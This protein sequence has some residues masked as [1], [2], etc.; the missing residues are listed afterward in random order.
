M[1]YNDDSHKFKN[2]KNDQVL[3][4]NIYTVLLIISSNFNDKSIHKLKS[5]RK[6]FSSQSILSV[7]NQANKRYV[8]FQLSQFI[9]K[10]N[11]KHSKNFQRSDFSNDYEVTTLNHQIKN[12]EK[13]IFILNYFSHRLK[14]KKEKKT[15]SLKKHI[16]KWTKKIE[17]LRQEL[18]YY[19]NTRKILMKF[20]ENINES[21]RM[22]KNILCETFKNVAISEQRLLN[23]WSINDCNYVDNVF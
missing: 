5:W 13:T 22:I 7:K 11:I 12:H 9:S 14:L 18:I 6:K 10:R 2:M 8:T 21:H 17:Y 20:Y 23:Y 1:T 16:K 15:K 19:K 3:S 4:R